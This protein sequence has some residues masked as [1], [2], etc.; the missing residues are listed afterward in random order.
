MLK[1]KKFVKKTKRGAVLT[2]TAEHYLRRDIWCGHA[3][4][5]VCKNAVPKLKD[6]DILVP[7]TNVV[8]HQLDVLQ[9]P[10]ID[11][12]VLL[13]TVLD[14]VKHRDMSAYT[15][16]RA[17]STNQDRRFYVFAN[18]HFKATYI[19]RNDGES[20]ND[21][22]DRAIRVAAKWYAQHI[23]EALQSHSTAMDTDD[24]C[25]V[26]LLTNDADNGRKAKADGLHAVSMRDYI[27]KDLNAPDLEDL[28]PMAAS[29]AAALSHTEFDNVNDEGAGAGGSTSTSNSGSVQYLPYLTAAAIQAG[30]K[31]KALL[32]GTFHASR[33]S[34]NEGFVSAR[35]LDKPVLVRGEAM[36][37]A[38]DRDVVVVRLLDKREWT[39]PSDVVEG[40]DATT[41]GVPG[42]EGPQD[43][44]VNQVALPGVQATGRVVGI[45]RRLWRPYCGVLLKSDNPN[46]RQHLF[47]PY[48]RQIPRIR[49]Q[50][51]QA[52]TFEGK[53]IVVAI[54]DWPVD[55]KHPVGHYVKTLGDAGD[56]DVETEVVLIEHEVPYQ[57]FSAA[58]HAEMPAV[59]WTVPPE[60]FA[61]RRD[62]REYNICSV[63]PPGCTDIDDALHARQLPNGNIEVGVHI[64]DVTH[65]IRPGSFAD[66]E[67]AKRSTTVYL[68]RRRIDMV[69]P[70]LSSN[71]CSLR[72]NEERLAVSTVWEM[73]PN[74]EIV[75][76]EFFKSVIKSKSAMMYSEA[77]MRIDDASDNSELTNGLRI[78]NKLAKKLKQR[79]IEAGALLLASPEV[80]FSVESQTHDPVDVEVK[81]ALDTHSLVEEFMLLANVTVARHI[82]EQF[83]ACA[84]LRRHPTPPGSNFEPLILAAKGAGI[85]LDTSSSRGLAKSLDRAE[86]CG[87]PYVATLLRILATRCMLQAVYFCS[88]M[89]A[90]PEFRHYGLASEI[91]THFT[92]P[93]RRYADIIVHRLLAASIG[94]DATYPDLVAKDK[95]SDLCENINFRHTMAQRA[96]RASND[97]Y[98]HILFTGKVV[99]E[100]GYVLR[101][102][103]NAV[104]VLVPRY[105]IEGNVYFAEPGKESDVQA[106]YDEETLHLTIKGVEFAVFDRV[107][108]QVSVEERLQT[109]RIILKLVRPVIDGVSVAA[110]ESTLPSLLDLPTG[111][112]LTRESSSTCM[113]G[114]AQ[115][116]ST[117]GVK[118]HA[119][120]TTDTDTQPAV[121]VKK[122]SK[123]KK[124]SKA[125]KKRPASTDAAGDTTVTKRLG[126]H[127]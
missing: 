8:L 60:E 72:G 105:G 21:R 18:E 15:R 74:A 56:A 80:R 19:D 122:G 23:R 17:L 123:K 38:V 22:N 48:N 45:V 4:C 54:D 69:P 14:E 10:K 71:I 24:L 32:Q 117:T 95:T 118:A 115:R 85:E 125:S 33:D 102:R 44:L 1:S 66:A 110:Q 62:L 92:S 52:S 87:R 13:S 98:C 64:A 121:P 68:T 2:V 70:V 50:T 43:A 5:V 49:I 46:R 100:E 58:I 120:V 34:S 11:N 37:R 90:E 9:D 55:S 25:R 114:D 126:L 76:V 53:R 91:Y 59:P 16:I 106:K 97:L 103:R 108:V 61:K 28:L 7:D 35:G 88:G 111:A 107:V 26:V 79:R 84:M 96:S 124:K 101:T 112:I 81:Q 47:Q 77:Q 73:T 40:D 12:V 93:I 83:P 29:E 31:T 30:L 63:D 116:S 75:S 6:G 20:P 94:A 113:D 119:S 89:V 99:D 3:R 78:L 57:P 109:K 27:V 127:Q 86:S 42:E 41:V 36:N 67:A 39:R 104:T 65:F 82:Y 51:R